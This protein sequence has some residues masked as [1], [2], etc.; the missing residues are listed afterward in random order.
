MVSKW[1]GL[2]KDHVDSTGVR[3][4]K[5]A[6]MF[7][8]TVLSRILFRSPT[9]DTAGGV[10]GQLFEGTGTLENVGIGV[11]AAIV[12]AMVLHWTPKAWRESLKS[13]FSG[14]PAIVQGLGIVVVGIIIMEVATSEVVPYIYF[15]F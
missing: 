13:W 3:I 15:A 2:P 11:W 6:L 1:R 8:F 14:L 5:I 7:H 12:G 4:W 10:W 9:L